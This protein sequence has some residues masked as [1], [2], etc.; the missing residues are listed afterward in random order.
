MSSRTV[1]GIA[2]ATAFKDVFIPTEQCCLRVTPEYPLLFDIYR[3]M[4]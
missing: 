3:G 1:D 4:K 2:Q